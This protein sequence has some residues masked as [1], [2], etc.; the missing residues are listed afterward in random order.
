MKR[1]RTESHGI[2]KFI[3]RILLPKSC[4]NPLHLRNPGFIRV[5]KIYYII[6]L[7]M[8]FNTNH[9]TAIPKYL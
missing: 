1:I 4:L 2:K 6:T 8:K 3:Y 5:Q 7:D 9:D